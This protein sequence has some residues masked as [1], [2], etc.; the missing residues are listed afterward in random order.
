MHLG[1]LGSNSTASVSGET[2]GGEATS[3]GSIAHVEPEVPATENTV[4][5]DFTS[6]S[7]D[8]SGSN[9]KGGR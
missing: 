1:F 2:S 6:K 8:F 5:P 7:M 4:V 9:V 3:V